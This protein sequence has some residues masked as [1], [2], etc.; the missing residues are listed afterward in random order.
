[1]TR[2]ERRDREMTG[3]DVTY[4]QHVDP[5][6]QRHKSLDLLSDHVDFLQRHGQRIKR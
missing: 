6:G 3:H 5:R 2:R 1:M 4:R